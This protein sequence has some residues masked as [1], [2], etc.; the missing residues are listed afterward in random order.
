MRTSILCSIEDDGS[1]NMANWNLVR[2]FAGG[3]LVDVVEGPYR[4]ASEKARELERDND[5][6]II[7][8]QSF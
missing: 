1:G 4:V 6:E 3:Q 8:Y 7:I 5:W 2:E